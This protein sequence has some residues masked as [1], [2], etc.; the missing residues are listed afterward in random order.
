M[1]P[2]MTQI[3]A[4]R[5]IRRGP[6]VHYA[7]CVPHS[8]SQSGF[9]LLELLISMAV[10]ALLSVL[11]L[12][13]TGGATTVVAS[14]R[15]RLDADNQARLIFDRMANDFA[16]MTK[17]KDADCIFAKL[18]GG[19]QNDAMFFFSEA[20][21][22]F[23]STNSTTTKSTVALVGYRINFNNASYPNTPV[24]ERLGKGLTWDGKTGTTTPGGT[25]F[26]TTPS[27]SATPDPTSTIAG[28][29]QNLGTLAGANASA[30]ADGNDPDYTVLS[31]QVYRLEIAFLL[32]DG[33]VSTMPVTNP[34]TTTNNLAATAAPASSD[35]SSK[36]Y[37]VG[38]RWY[39]TTSKQGYICA[40]AAAG[41]AVWD[42]V[43][44]RDVAAVIVAI[45]ILSPGGRKLISSPDAY[46]GLIGTLGDAVAG[47]PVLKT[48]NGWNGSSYSSPPP[49]LANSGIPKAAASQIRTYQRY[50]HLNN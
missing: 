17:R 31:D 49:Y 33:N 29:W 26:L 45:A 50:F 48:W 9:T 3:S 1:D 25:V 5:G 16:R 37:A 42:P 4:D 39:N 11:V 38:S 21:A 41:A 35:D 18:D 46:A 36:G 13:L 20:P 6:S 34:A 23:N 7:L 14:S 10:L 8:S 44:I 12:Q 28:N 47:T 30:Y 27:G 2:Q 15:K 22:Y 40:S 32:T 24:L 43:G 19:G